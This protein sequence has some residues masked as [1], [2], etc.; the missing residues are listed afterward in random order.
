MASGSVKKIIK[1]ITGELPASTG[2]SIIS[3]V[4][5]DGYLVVSCMFYTTYNQWRPLSV[6]QTSDGTGLVV[7]GLAQGQISRPYRAIVVAQ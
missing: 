4:I 3:S 2:D 7:L 5:P 1:I 6:G